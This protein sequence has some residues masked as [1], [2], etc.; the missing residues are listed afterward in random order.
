MADL[1]VDGRA[2]ALREA[3][4]IQRCGDAAP[5]G[6]FLV[7]PMVNLLGGN[8]RVD[9]LRNVIQHRDV[10][11]RAFADSLDLRLVLNQLT[12]R[13]FKALFPQRLILLVKFFMASLI[14]FPAPAPA[15]RV[16]IHL[17]HTRPPFTT[18]IIS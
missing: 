1:I 6:G 8:A 7:D 4:V 17:I 13:H 18:R 2:D 9:M 11:L 5:A 12:L 10:D 3:L 14:S 15:G 16:P